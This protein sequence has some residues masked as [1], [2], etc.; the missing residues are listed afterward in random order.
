M[1]EQFPV[2]V[3]IQ[4]RWGDMD[5]L[6]HVNNVTYF[7]YIE[8]ARIAYFHRVNMN[9]LWCEEFGPIVASASC[10]FKM[11]VTYP[12]WLDVGARITRVGNSSMTMAYG[13]Y[14]KDSNDLVAQGSTS[15]VWVNYHEGKG[16]R[17]PDVLRSAIENLEPELSDSARRTAPTS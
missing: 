2:W 15:I 16:V 7:T 4:V 17:L 9:K 12:A 13:L 8:M 5:A 11:P 1:R 10:D 14:L 6:G 3:P